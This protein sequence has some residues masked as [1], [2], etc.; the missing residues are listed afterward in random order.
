MVK[1]CDVC[2]VETEHPLEVS[3]GRSVHTFCSFQ[4]AIT[5]LAPKCFSCG[6]KILGRPFEA[7]EEIYCSPECSTMNEG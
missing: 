2:R 7:D 3:Y 1:Q 6:C 5:R 4:C